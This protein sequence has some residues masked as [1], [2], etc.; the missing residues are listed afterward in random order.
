M[1]KPAPLCVYYD[2]DCPI[3]RIEVRF[4]ERIDKADVI[5]WI[6]ITPLSDSALPDGKTR[7]ELLGKFHVRDD[8]NWHIGVDAFARIWRALPGFRHFAFLF[9]VPILRQMAMGLYL[10][11]L[12]WQ[13]WHR[14]HRARASESL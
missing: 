4:Y 8:E 14:K 3:C 11:F 12:R 5:S 2:G 1:N 9:R 10:V 7:E 6:N 13:R